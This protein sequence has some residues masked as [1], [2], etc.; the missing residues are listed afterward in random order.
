M[1]GTHMRNACVR[2][3]RTQ[4]AD[5]YA[6]YERTN[7]TDGRGWSSRDPSLNLINAQARVHPE[8]WIP[9]MVTA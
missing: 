4:D 1:S 2:A 3:V 5:A 9:R 7:G 8:V 6:T